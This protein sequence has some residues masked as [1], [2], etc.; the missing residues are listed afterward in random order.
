MSKG[1][2]WVF[3]RYRQGSTC[4]KDNIKNNSRSFVMWWEM[5]FRV[6]WDAILHL[7]SWKNW[8]VCSYQVLGQVERQRISYPAS[9]LAQLPGK[10]VLS[11]S[12]RVNL[13]HFQ[14]F[15]FMYICT[16]NSCTYAPGNMYTNVMV[17]PY[18]T[19][20]TWENPKCLWAKEWMNKL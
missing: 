2:E 9:K 13:P 10:I 12:H 20:N 3:Y 15:A 7:F 8:K 11:L 18:T 16:R 19:S 14:H 17:A 1:Y 5:Q 4:G 6:T